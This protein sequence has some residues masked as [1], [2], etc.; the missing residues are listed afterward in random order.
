MEDAWHVVDFYHM[1][2]GAGAPCS[3]ANA[4][5][6]GG[7]KAIVHDN[8]QGGNWFIGEKGVQVGA[9]A[10][11]VV[12]AIDQHESQSGFFLLHPAE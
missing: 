9:D 2:I 5:A 6:A 11:R 1:Q 7:V 12:C 4:F 10:I 3:S 8:P